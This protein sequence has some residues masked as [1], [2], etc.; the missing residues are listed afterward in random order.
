[1]PIATASPSLMQ[2]LGLPF[3]SAQ[4][5]CNHVSCE[6]PL[7][8]KRPW[9]LPLYGKIYLIYSLSASSLEAASKE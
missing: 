2:C 5:W 8:G 9:V 3:A 1:M 7:S 4:Q 6:M